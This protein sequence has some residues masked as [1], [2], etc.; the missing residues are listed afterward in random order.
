MDIYIGKISE[1]MMIEVCEAQSRSSRAARQKFR[2]MSNRL[3]R[4]VAGDIVLRDDVSINCDERDEYDRCSKFEI[5]FCCSPPTTTTVQTTTTEVKEFC[6][7]SLETTSENNM[8]LPHEKFKTGWVQINLS[9]IP[10]FC[11]MDKK[12][13]NSNKIITHNNCKDES[14]KMKEM[15]Y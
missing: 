5:R 6:P 8:F 10:N 12:V 9:F 15:F 2:Q 1:E 14:H 4:T 7:D 13:I 11:Q 3:P